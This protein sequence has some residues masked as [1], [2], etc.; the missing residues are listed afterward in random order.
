MLRAGGGLFFDWFDALSYEQAIQLDG[1][2]QQI[3]TI[4]GPG[5]PDSTLGG[6]ARSYLLEMGHGV[7]GE[8]YH[9]LKDPDAEVRAVLC[10]I[11]GTIGD[12]DTIAHLT[13]LLSDPNSGVVDRATRAI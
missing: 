6:R 3:E 5:Y 1:T 9:Y 4:V 13:P 8:L 11:L 7:V 12:A 10:D 2:H